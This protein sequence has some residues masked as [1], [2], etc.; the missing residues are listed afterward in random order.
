MKL[1]TERSERKPARTSAER[2]ARDDAMR[3][4]APTT[5]TTSKG[6]TMSLP[7]PKPRSFR[8]A[9]ASFAAEAEL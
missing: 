8:G 4:V 9:P 2:L 6:E 1:P 7:E 3:A 5:V